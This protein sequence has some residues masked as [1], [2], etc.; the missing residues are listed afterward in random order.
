MFTRR[1]SLWWLLGPVVLYILALPLYNRIEPVIL[2]L[3]FFMAWTLLATILTPVCVW[4]AARN[5]PLFQA[6]RKRDRSEPT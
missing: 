3:P 4:L 2:G 1:R 6:D 5:D